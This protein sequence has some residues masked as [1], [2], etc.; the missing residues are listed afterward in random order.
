MIVIIT[1]SYIYQVCAKKMSLKISIIDFR[2]NFLEDEC[3][4]IIIAAHF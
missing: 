2:G 3:S 4:K 1:L